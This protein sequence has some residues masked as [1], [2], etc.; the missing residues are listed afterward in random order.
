VVKHVRLSLY[1]KEFTKLVW[2]G[3]NDIMYV[4][5]KVGSSRCEGLGNDGIARLSQAG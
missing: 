2:E 3:V 1:Q 5:A 4:T